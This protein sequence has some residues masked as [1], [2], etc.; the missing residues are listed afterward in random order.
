MLSS[1]L[2]DEKAA[3]LNVLTEA[4]K[5]EGWSLL[6]DGKDLSQWKNYQKDGVDPKW[7]VADGAFTLTEKG[8]G[9]I[10]TKEQYGSF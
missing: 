5:A 1:V 9:D 10:L 3:G 2:A 8:G 7:Q 4:E 6:F